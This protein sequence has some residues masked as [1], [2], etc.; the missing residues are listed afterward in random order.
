MEGRIVE[1]EE[2]SLV[3]EIVV[4]IEGVALGIVEGFNEG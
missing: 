4:L 1:V 2:R 3:G